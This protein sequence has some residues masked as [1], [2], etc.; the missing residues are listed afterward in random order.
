M[1]QNFRTTFPWD[2]INRKIQN[3]KTEFGFG[4]GFENF[5]EESD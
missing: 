4:T 3:S 2:T 5:L 1:P